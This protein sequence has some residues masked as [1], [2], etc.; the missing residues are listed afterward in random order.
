MKALPRPLVGRNSWRVE[1]PVFWVGVLAVAYLLPGYLPLLTQIVIVG[2]FAASLDLLVGYAGLASLGHSVFF[3]VGAYTA[4][5]LM[6]HGWGEPL[7]GLVAAAVVSGCLG[8]LFS[9]LL[10]KVRGI[11]LLIVTLGLGLFVLELATQTKWLTGGD[12][13]L[14]G[15]AVWPVLGLVDWDFLGRT[16]FVYAFIVCAAL[17]VILRLITRSTFGLAVEAIRE[18]EV[19]AKAIGI[20]AVRRLQAVVVI[21]AA[22]AGVAGALYS[23]T[24]QYVALDVLSLERS[25]SALVMITL[26]GVGTTIGALIGAAT[27]LWARDLFASLAPVYWN[28][29]IGLLLFLIVCMGQSGILGLTSKLAALRFAGRSRNGG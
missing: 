19:R 5:I 23:Q 8:Y 18:N 16:S 21:S 25:V 6:Q 13:G 4:G 28:F 12:D 9:F 2:L 11:A 3:G 14:Q 10:N 15:I 22:I 29:W 24:T 17:Y 27:F 1:E 7:S 20:P 26:G